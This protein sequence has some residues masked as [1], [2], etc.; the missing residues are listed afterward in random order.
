MLVVDRARLF[1]GQQ[2]FD[3]WPSLT[4]GGVAKQ[5]HDNSPSLDGFI[6]FKEIRSRNPSILLSFFPRGTILP[7]ANDDVE[8]VV[9][10]IETLAVTLGAVTDERKSIILEVL[11]KQYELSAMGQ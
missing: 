2:R 11:L 3:S 9:T 4:L 8:P 10:Q 5:V 1:L 6:D 7:H